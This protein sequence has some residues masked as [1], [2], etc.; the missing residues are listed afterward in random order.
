[1]QRVIKTELGEIEYRSRGKGTPILILHGGHSNCYEHLGVTGFDTSIYQLIVPSR[2][3]YGKT[4]LENH[5]SPEQAADLISAMIDQIAIEKVIVIGISAGGLTA[6]ALASR[7]PDKVSK[8]ILASA[9]TKQW[10]SKKGNVYKSAKRLFNP[11]SQWLTWSI[12]RLFG[13]IIPRKLASQFQQQFSTQSPHPQRKEDVDKLMDALRYYSSGSGFLNDIDQTLGFNALRKVS[14]PVLI[15]HSKNDNSVPYDH[16]VYA[17]KLIE[18]SILA[19]LQNN[20]GHMIWLG[21]DVGEVIRL[22]LDFIKSSDNDLFIQ[23]VQT[24]TS[25]RFELSTSTSLRHN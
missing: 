1:M 24:Y 3:G 10:L 20:W 7:H 21:Q 11:L 22:Q 2:P 4:P 23:K 8:L 5:K 6:I 16:A 17:N 25:G 15:L 9:V 19:G 12:V 18:S 14:C 13:R